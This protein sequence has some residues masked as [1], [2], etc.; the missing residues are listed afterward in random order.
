MLHSNIS[1]Y[2][3]NFWLKKRLCIIFSIFFLFCNVE[4]ALAN[5]SNIIEHKN[6]INNN[7]AKITKP[8]IREKNGELIECYLE[9]ELGLEDGTLKNWGKNVS[10]SPK[11]VFI[12]Q[13]KEGIC[14]IVKWAA[15]EEQNLKIRAS[16]YRHTWNPVYP[17]NGQILI[18]L[19]GLKYLNSDESSS[20]VYDETGAGEELKTIEYILGSTESDKIYCKIGGAVTNDELRLFCLN[21]KDPFYNSYW[22]IPYNV[23]LVENTLSG[24]ISSI[25]HGAGANNKT[26]SDL[27]EE[28]EFVNAKG[29]LQT[30]NKTTEPDLMPAAA[31]SFGLLGIITSITLKL[32][33]MS[34]SLTDPRLVNLAMAIPLP[35]GTRLDQMPKKLQE[36]L[37]IADQKTLDSI[38]S[39]NNEMFFDRCNDYYAEWFWF[40]LNKNCWINSWN[41]D[42]VENDQKNIEDWMYGGEEIYSYLQAWLQ[43][44]MSSFVE[45]FDVEDFQMPP[46]PL[47]EIFV[48][49]SSA[50][51]TGLLSTKPRALPLPEALHFQHGIRHIHVRDVE[52]EI[53]ITLKQDGQPDWTICQKAW[54]DAIYLIY[55]HLEET[56]TLPVNLTLEM[57]IMGGSDITM[58][59]QRGNQY[60]CSI[61][62]LSTMLVPHEEWK[63]LAEK[64]IACWISYK[65]SENKPLSIHTH[66][67]KEWHGLQFN[68]ID[69]ETY[70]RNS[71]P[72][73]IPK[74]KEQL[75]KIAAAGGYTLDD[76][77]E[78]FSNSLWD[79]IF[80]HAMD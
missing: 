65:D 68:G 8:E 64:I 21:N 43:N 76:I 55:T 25:C 63:T 37:G 22:T 39:Q 75:T 6:L 73:A 28:I 67:A 30:I 17:D 19:L 18:S 59:A 27:V 33:K 57:R 26:L 10:F 4:L 71:Y 52:I 31:G 12:P 5:N 53:P 62:V 56:G 16:G 29:E 13:T 60:T 7:S 79:N 54:W 15:A 44:S 49:T 46:P 38:I 78:R 36:D 50:I 41:K 2:K 66:W 9:S 48:R 51:I 11:Y 45:L 69:A 61:E 47:Q 40:I 58:A 72:E 32:D 77:R 20:T 80:F 42:S 3:I 14:N 24:T 34:Y 70:V 74:F 35:I 23:I 1:L